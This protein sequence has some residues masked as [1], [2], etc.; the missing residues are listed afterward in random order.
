MHAC[1][2]SIFLY[3][4]PTISAVCVCAHLF[5]DTYR[6]AYFLYAYVAYYM[7]VSLAPIFEFSFIG[8]FRYS[9]SMY[10]CVYLAICIYCAFIETYKFF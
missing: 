8:L 9:Y 1:N 10:V 7:H 5:I 3:S 4:T 6:P 2:L